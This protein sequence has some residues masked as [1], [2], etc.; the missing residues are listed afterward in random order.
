MG[1]LCPTRRNDPWFLRRMGTYGDLARSLIRRRAKSSIASKLLA[2]YSIVQ[3]QSPEDL[4]LNR[5]LA[6]VACKASYLGCNTPEPK[7]IAKV[8]P[9]IR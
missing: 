1:D 5:L 4:A 3:P 7:E 6:G 2:S 9:A 8:R